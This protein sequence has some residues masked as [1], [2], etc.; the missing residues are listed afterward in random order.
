MFKYV[1]LIVLVCVCVYVASTGGNL[2]RVA[3]ESEREKKGMFLRLCK[4]F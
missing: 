4:M 3:A 2:R 1:L